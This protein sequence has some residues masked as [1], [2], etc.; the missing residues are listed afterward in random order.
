M[1]VPLPE[2]VANIKRF[3]ESNPNA[4]KDDVAKAAAVSCGLKKIGKVYACDDYAL[5]FSSAK[6]SS[7]SNTVLSLKKVKDFD[8][9]PFVVVVCRPSSTEFLL[10]NTT[11]LKKISH[12][13]HQLRVDNIR[14]SFLGHDIVREYEGVANA[15]ANFAELFARHQEFT[16]QENLERLVEATNS[17]AGTGHRFEPADTQ[18][19]TILEA[20][21]LAIEIT[22]PHS[23][24]PFRRISQ[25]NS[26][27]SVISGV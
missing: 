12:S 25:E 1:P 4:T 15:P 17:I 20:P 21:A 24:E 11:L 6:G 2:A 3:R 22:N 16:W 10:A 18:R 27:P 9:V 5:R 14:G 19:T 23:S 26:K 7:F 13:S 8:H